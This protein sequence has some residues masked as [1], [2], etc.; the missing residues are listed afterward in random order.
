MAD[1][2][3]K[4]FDDEDFPELKETKNAIILLCIKLGGKENEE[5]MAKLKEFEPTGN[6]KK[7]KDLGEAEKLL[8]ILQQMEKSLP[9]EEKKTQEEKK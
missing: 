7:I 5:L 2:A 4:L 6:P 9:K 3:D 1:K 8:E